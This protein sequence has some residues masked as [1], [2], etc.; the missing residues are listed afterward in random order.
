[1]SIS[2]NIIGGGD[3]L[4]DLRLYRNTL[5]HKNDI[6]LLGAKYGDELK[7]YFLNSDVFLLAGSGGLAINEAMAYGLPI[8][9]AN[10]DGSVRDLIENNGYLLH[11]FGC[12][13]EIQE[14][15][16]KF[17]K[18]SRK[19]KIAMSENS[20]RIIKNKATISLMVENYKNAIF[21]LLNHK[22]K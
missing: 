1:M 21:Y 10:G 19:E 4:E 16:T 7:S 2:F 17:Y 3:I 6:H 12:K 15:V 22:V 18:L 14:S 8:I 9:S 13:Y 11:N 20:V 5:I